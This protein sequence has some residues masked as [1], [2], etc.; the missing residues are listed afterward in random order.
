M[1]KD[2]FGRIIDYLRLSITEDCNLNCFYCRP[3]GSCNSSI[4]EGRILSAQEIYKIAL[5]FSKMGIKKIRI[6]G[7][8]PLLRKDLVEIIESIDGIDGVTD[9]SLTTNG[10]MLGKKAA[11]LKDAGLNRVNISMDSLNPEALKKIT[12]GVTNSLLEEGIAESLKVGLTPIKINVVIMKGINDTEIDNFIN[13][14]L[15]KSIDVRFIEF[16]PIASEKDIWEKY[17]VSLTEVEKYCQNKYSLEESRGDH[18][19]GP[20]KYYQIKGATGKIGFITP[21]SRHFCK[22]CGR[23]RV[24]SEGMIKPCLFTEDQVPLLPFLD[25]PAEF[26]NV[27]LKAL[28]LRPNPEIAALNPEKRASQ[29]NSGKKM[30]SIGG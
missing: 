21:L 22:D 17:F 27:V 9:L 19:G 28:K 25:K 8:E 13:L 23:L 11:K 7:G 18:G 30:S 1:L 4:K 2:E 24:T 16:M 10:T 6:T 29:C 15:N 26:K 14:T 12:Q 5:N 3:G 20:A